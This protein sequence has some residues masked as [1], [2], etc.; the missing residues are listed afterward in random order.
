VLQLDAYANRWYS[1]LLAMQQLQQQ[2]GSCALM[3]V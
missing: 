2:Q 3:R 1:Q